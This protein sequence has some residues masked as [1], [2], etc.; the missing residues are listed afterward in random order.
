MDVK[1]SAI[2][3]LRE[4]GASLFRILDTGINPVYTLT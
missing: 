4:A 2:Q 1:T 3:V